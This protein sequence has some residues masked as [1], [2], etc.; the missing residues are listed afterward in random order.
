VLQGSTSQAALGETAYLALLV[1]VVV[2]VLVLGLVLACWWQCWLCWPWRGGRT[3]G[4]G[5]LQDHSI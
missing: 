2:L 3:S 4:T 1:V 5:I